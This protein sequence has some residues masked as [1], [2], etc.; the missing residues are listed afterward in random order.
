MELLS[1]GADISVYSAD[2][3]NCLHYAAKNDRKGIVEILLRSGADPS[4]PNK[5]GILPVELSN[6]ASVRELF[7]RDRST[8][9]SPIVQTR[10]L[11][12]DYIEQL[13]LSSNPSKEATVSSVQVVA[14][15]ADDVSASHV[16]NKEEKTPALSSLPTVSES[17]EENVSRKTVFNM[18]DELDEAESPDKSDL[19]LAI[20]T[21]THSTDDDS[22]LVGVSTPAPY[23][24][25]HSALD[26]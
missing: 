10:M 21:E 15:V 1:Q 12:S 9:F 3:N 11:L 7:L 25:Q 20:P 14:N 17:N 2:G 6:D 16:V 4:I 19:M 5:A 22:C 13:S 18:A 8:I 23:I 24:R 26:K